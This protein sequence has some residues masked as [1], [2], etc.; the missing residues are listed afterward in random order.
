MKTI[1]DALRI[2]II[3]TCCVNISQA[4]AQEELDG[5]IE[6]RGS[7]TRIPPDP[8]LFDIEEDNPA[9]PRS[10]RIDPH[11]S[12][13]RPAVSIEFDRANPSKVVD[14]ITKD[15][16]TSS[17]RESNHLSNIRNGLKLLRQTNERLRN[18]SDSHAR[19]LEIERQRTERAE[20]IA[21][22]AKRS[23]ERSHSI[24]VEAM[25]RMVEMHREQLEQFE[26]Q[27]KQQM[28][29]FLDEGPAFPADEGMIPAE[30]LPQPP[31]SSV[32][33]TPDENPR[34]AEVPTPAVEKKTVEKQTLPP[35]PTTPM[36]DQAVDRNALADSLFG[37]QEFRSAIHVYYEL[38]KDPPEGG[39]VDWYNYQIAC[40]SRNLEDYDTAEKYYR[41]VAAA[42]ES[43][44]A[45]TARWW[46]SL[47]ADKR[48]VLG[49]LAA[50][51]QT[52]TEG[53]ND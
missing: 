42:K 53:T 35:T 15:M 46:L 24:T 33:V 4:V 19:M 1:N 49:Q 9:R 17:V 7:D 45:P 13:E 10:I 34:V 25:R 40:C 51:K 23:A 31:T 8:P 26:L 47:I 20:Q 2:L 37:A 27:K 5:V 12:D 11:V 44:L 41:R 32:I 21:E 14:Q 48:E 6:Y 3:V 50:F 28:K 22:D 29:S 39:D 38:Q 16:T 18:T 36:T 43:F 30:Q 52:L